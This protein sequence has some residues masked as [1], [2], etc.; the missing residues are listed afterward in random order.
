MSSDSQNITT[1]MAHADIMRKAGDGRLMAL[2]GRSLDYV[3][4]DF[5]GQMK[6][7]EKSKTVRAQMD[8]LIWE[9]AK[10]RI[11]RFLKNNNITLHLT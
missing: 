1:V 6:Q 10:P 9:H 11:V 7:V 3:R 8:K 5:P 4:V 2:I